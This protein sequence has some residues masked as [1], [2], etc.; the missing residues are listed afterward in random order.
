KSLP[1]SDR[2]TVLSKVAL[3]LVVAP[4][5]VIAIG[6]VQ[7]LLL[8]LAGC[9]MLLI[10]GTNMFSAVLASPDLYL[11][12]LRVVA[13]LPVYMLWALP[14]VGWLLMVSSMARSKVF[15]WAVGGPLLVAMLVGWADK[16][17]HLGLDSAWFMH[18]IVARILLGA[19][20]GSWF[21]FTDLDDRNLMHSDNVF[22]ASWATLGN[23][24][25]WA[26][27]AAGAAMIAVA[28]WMRRRREE[29]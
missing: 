14:T 7:S 20:P 1:V 2:A 28:V 12:P 6:T 25:L 8:L 17:L 4:L 13:L 9:A 3:A 15:L 21:L 11:A 5:I 29:G 27:V 10:H 16:V 26:G 19:A 23:V 24:S 22:G 18:A